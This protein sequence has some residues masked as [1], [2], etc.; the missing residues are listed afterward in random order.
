ML[1]MEKIA[2]VMINQNYSSIDVIEAIC[3]KISSKTFY[4]DGES[5]L[6]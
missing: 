6:Q 3:G 2:Y 5:K 1:R 4:E